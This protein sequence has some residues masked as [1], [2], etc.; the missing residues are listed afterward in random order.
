[1][2]EAE[3]AKVVAEAM[4]AQAPLLPSLED[5]LWAKAILKTADAVGGGILY[6]LALWVLGGNTKV[7]RFLFKYN[8]EVA[9]L[10]KQ[11]QDKNPEINLPARAA[12]ARVN[13]ARILGFAIVI[14]LILAF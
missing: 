4:A 11:A 2:T 1:M 10:E 3:I 14:G 13:S 12:L 9:L 8:D 6:L 5:T 7:G